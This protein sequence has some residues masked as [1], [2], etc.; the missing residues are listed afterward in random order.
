V[1][2]SKTRRGLGLWLRDPAWNCWSTFGFARHQLFGRSM[3]SAGFTTPSV[4]RGLAGHRRVSLRSISL[5]VLMH[6]LDSKRSG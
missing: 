4:R 6:G 5:V 3:S 1:Q 2:P